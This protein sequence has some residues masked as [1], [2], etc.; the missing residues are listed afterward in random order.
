MLGLREGTLK[1]RVHEVD[2]DEDAEQKE[3]ESVLADAEYPEAE[4]VDSGHFMGEPIQVLHKN[5]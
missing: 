3:A 5:Y 2:I 4:K 1:L